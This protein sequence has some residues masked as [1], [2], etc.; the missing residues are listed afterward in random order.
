MKPDRQPNWPF[1]V[2]PSSSDEFCNRRS[3][4]ASTSPPLKDTSATLRHRPLP[5]AS[6]G[7]FLSF[8]DSRRLRV[9]Q[10]VD[11]LSLPFLSPW[12]VGDEFYRPLGISFG[13]RWRDRII[14]MIFGRQRPE[15][16]TNE[17]TA[18]RLSFF[19]KHTPSDSWPTRLQNLRLLPSNSRLFYISRSGV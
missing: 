4:P 3:G 9:D 14:M 17:K 16:D 10:I 11:S 7:S 18:C 1:L 6:P 12:A 13:T 5:T 8:L 15:Q 2:V 19:N